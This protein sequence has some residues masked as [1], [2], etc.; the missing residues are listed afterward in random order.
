MVENI[1]ERARQRA[2][3]SQS[4]LA[5]R[6]ATSQATLSTY[7]NG[8]KS[9]TLTV[10]ERILSSSGHRLELSPTVEFVTHTGARGE[11][12]HVPDHLWRLHPEQA[13]ATVTLPQHLQWSG[14]SRKYRLRNR[15][16]RARVYEIVLRE[17]SESDLISLIDGVLLI[18]LWDE[19]VIPQPIRDAWEP[20]ISTAGGTP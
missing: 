3:L 15:R 14:T 17:G 13:L 16:D 7:E 9:P 4:E 1:I 20:I 19:L 6:S 2:G 8:H 11:P 18:D 5:H 10:L 12:F